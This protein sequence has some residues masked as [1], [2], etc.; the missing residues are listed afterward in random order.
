MCLWLTCGA[1][2]IPSGIGRTP[3]SYRKIRFSLQKVAD[4]VGLYLSPPATAVVLCVD[5]KSGVQAYPG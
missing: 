5:E 4:I 2:I 3:S 1:N